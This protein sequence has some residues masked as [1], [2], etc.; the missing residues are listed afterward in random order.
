MITKEGF[1]IEYR[2]QVVTVSK[3]VKN[4]ESFDDQL[5]SARLLLCHFR[6]KGGSEWGCDGVG[7][8]VQKRIGMVRVNRSGVSKA[9]Y[10]AGI[11]A[12]SARGS[13]TGAT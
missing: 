5:A 11:A 7:Y 1:T 6:A 9:G 8:G 12:I 13:K 4:G 10:G 2:D 3:S